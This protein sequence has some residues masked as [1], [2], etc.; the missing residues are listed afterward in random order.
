[1]LSATA[2]TTALAVSLTSN[3]LPVRA[4]PLTPVAA[5]ADV[6]ENGTYDLN[7]AARMRAEQCLLNLTL[8]R[9]GQELKSLS[10][11]GLNGTEAELHAAAVTEGW[12]NGNTPLALAWDKDDA[13]RQA[14]GRETAA[15]VD[16]WEESLVIPSQTTPPGYTVVGFE[17]IEDKDNPF[18]TTGLEAG[19]GAMYLHS[20]SDLYST[21]QTPVASKESVDAVNAIAAARYSEDR[22]EDRPALDALKWDMTFM[23]PMYADDARIFLQ[24]GGFPTTAPEP[25]SM[26]FRLDV[27]ALKA[28]FASCTTH[29]PLDPYGV[30]GAEV[31]QASVEWQNELAGQKAQRAVI[32]DAEAKASAQLRVASQAMGEALAQSLIAS[33]LTDWQAYWLKVP[34]STDFYPTPTEFAK[35]KTNIERARERAQGRVFVAGRAALAAQREAARADKAKAEAYAVA[36]AAGLPRGRGL[37]YGQQAVQVAKASAAAAQAAFK[38]TETAAHATRASAADSKT[39]QAL[40]QTQAHASKAEF[41]REAAEEAEAQAKAAAEGAAYQAKLAADN[42]TKAKAAQAKAEAA[43]ASAKTAAADAKA[44]REKAEAERDVAAA[45]RRRADSER[46]K[47]DAAEQRAVQERQ[48][49][50]DAL[51]RAQTAGATADGKSHEAA[52]ASVRA[53]EARDAALRAEQQKKAAEARAQA[54]EAAAAAAAG[55]SAAAET[56]QAASE[57]RTAA[58][59]AATHALS[60]R[61]AA[62]EA[63]AASVDARAAATRSEGAAARSQAAADSAAAAAAKTGAAVKQAHAAAAEAIDAS[64]AAAQNV[65]DAER[66][67]KEAAGKAV[68]ARQDAA[69]AQAEA[70]LARA[71]AVRAAGFAY[72]TAQ[73]AVAARDAA[74]QVIKPA[75]DAIELG[76][77]YKDTDVSAGLAV[78]IG[79]SS[80]TVA[81]Q[82]AALAKA[83]AVQ[84]KDAAALAATVAARASADAKAAAEAAARAADWASQAA[85]SLEQARAS[86]ADAKAAVEAAKKAEA[87]TVEYDRQANEDA[88]HAQVAGEEAATEAAAADASATDA[89]RDA[90][91]ARS[92]ATA[93][94]ADAST[95]QGVAT[96]A[97]AEAVAAEAAASDAQTYATEAD[98][99]ADRAEE[100]QRRLDAEERA[101]RLSAGTVDTGPVLSGDEESLLLAACGQACVD[102]FRAAKA[103]AGQDVLDWV[104]AN[105]GQV[106]I[107]MVGWTDAKTC[108][109]QGDIEGCLWTLL[110]GVSL[111]TLVGKIPAVTSAI[112]KIGG[113]IAKFLDQ[114]VTA[115]RTLDRLREVIEKT[116]AA[117]AG[118]S[119]LVNLAGDLVGSYA[120]RAGTMTVS[121]ATADKPAVCIRSAIEDDTGLTK[122]AKA[123]MQ[124]QGIKRDFD[125]LIKRLAEGAMPGS[126][127]KSLTG[128]GLIYFRTSKGARLFVKKTEDGWL[129]AGKSD[130]HNESNVMAR[131]KKI[132]G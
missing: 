124:N 51:A 56:R 17:W 85:A 122:M 99:A 61:S 68:K 72:A 49:A 57:A 31:V 37:M 74:S 58:D 118:A 32:M 97:E 130:K 44:K 11:K 131:L 123:A 50:A 100:E 109:T 69:A 104:V 128:T 115:K 12:W 98:Q 117:G 119:C 86:A 129:I 71:S 79:Q 60:A 19:L 33:R 6:P 62:D 95:A 88:L 102:E 48:A 63:T 132:Y 55:T 5:L 4:D 114:S 111:V 106:L 10:S 15:R 43:E 112:V 41:R 80:K 45:E 70:V 76:S 108:F 9:G 36:D 91:G 81:E 110:N 125:N 2:L 13:W 93:A 23:H 39:L 66:L 26:E 7:A 64:A 73:A 22:V 21:D 46:A 126:E 20:E 1:M 120:A 47:A 35:V 59:A 28:R 16:V 54:L 18:N 52:Q 116:K 53:I 30:L 24:H 83:K 77:P 92:A 42:A 34:S 78:L 90:A 113:G 121:A 3:Q 75:N 103:L 38:A 29:N 27:E 40:A 101:A 96:A 84:A 25:G 8:R 105:G 65:K 89:E 107:D 94:E 14:K 82:Q 87:N 127:Y 67:A